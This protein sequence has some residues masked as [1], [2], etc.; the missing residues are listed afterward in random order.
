[1]PVVDRELDSLLKQVSRSFYLT[2]RVLP[3]AIRPQIRLAYLLA[4]ATDTI[5]DTQVVSVSR[6][7]GALHQIRSAIQ[8]AAAG[9]QAQA[10]DLGE[11]AGAQEAPAGRGS[12]A[13]RTLL[14]SI[15]LVLESLG[16][17]SH[18][19]RDRVREVLETITRGQEMD[20]ARFGL[21][22]GEQIVALET[23]AEMEE[24]TYCVAG[25]VGE[26]WTKMSLAHLF[27]DAGL[28]RLP[29]LT[30]GIRFGKGLQL[31][32][33]LRDLPRDLRQG[34]C[35]IPR[36]RLAEIGLSPKDL[37][38]PLT[39]TRFRPLYDM[40]LLEAEEQLAAGWAYTN[41]LPRNE[42]RVR[43]ACTWPVLIG[44][45]TLSI[46]RTA[47]VLDDERRIKITRSEIRDLILRSILAYPFTAAWSHLFTGAQFRS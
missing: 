2:I 9:Y 23:D 15:S 16:N 40:Y 5:A 11:L 17:L 41:A 10:P 1:M 35:Y 19:D 39:I 22:S 4:R 24:Y 34:R 42:V 37:L 20:L 13:E 25:C 43:L 31:V 6:R 38:D 45:K 21:A 18:E 30:D 26:F 46:L 44:L 3:G 33:I 36:A 47:N 28:D 29:L 27:R 8:A 7:L 14:E 12:A 32:N